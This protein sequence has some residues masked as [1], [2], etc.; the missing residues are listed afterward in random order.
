MA[1][2]VLHFQVPADFSVKSINTFTLPEGLVL[3]PLLDNAHNLWDTFARLLS[4]QIHL[5]QA[6]KI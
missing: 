1:D 5:A 6:K 4:N 2:N 3:L